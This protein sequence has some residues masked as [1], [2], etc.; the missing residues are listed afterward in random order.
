M[1]ATLATPFHGNFDPSARQLVAGRS[2]PDLGPWGIRLPI[3]V[4][5]R[6]LGYRFYTHLH[7]YVRDL[8]KRL[9]EKSVPGLQGADT[10]YETNPDGTTVK[11]A[12]GKPRPTLFDEVFTADSY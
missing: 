1:N 2:Q 9:I 12:D 4:T 7:P 8:V 10:D 3:F 5:E 6:T 11:L